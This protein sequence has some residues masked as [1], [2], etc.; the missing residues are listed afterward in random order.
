MKNLQQFFVPDKLASLR[1]DL[2]LSEQLE[3]FSRTQIQSLIKEGKVLVNQKEVRKVA[4]L[5]SP[6]DCVDIELPATENKTKL[7]H[8]NIPLDIL[9]ED[10]DVVV[11]NKPAG[12]VV[13]PAPGHTS[14]TLVNALLYHCK[15]FVISGNPIRPGIVHRLDKNTS[16]VLVVAK[17]PGSYQHLSEQVKE[18]AFSRRY[19]ALVKGIPQSPQGTIEAGIGRS[20]LDP[21]RMS[22]TGVNAREAIT[23]FYLREN[24]SCFSL[25]ELKLNTGRTHQIRV[26]LRFIG[27]PIVGDPIYGFT[28]YDLLNLPAP[29]VNALNKLPGQALHA[30]SLGFTHPRTEQ[31]L[32]FT[33][34]LPNYFQNILNELHKYFSDTKSTIYPTKL[35]KS[36]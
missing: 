6:G 7:T 20:L 30:G 9:Y 16:G 27:H 25:L 4:F 1:L 3:G 14:G 21:K 35:G 17:N 18:R 29:V 8:E 22:V 28:D 32:E 5:I 26:H 23:H 36:R 31:F 34:P 11:V 24:F 12:L 19:F 13:H 10:K 15:D 2:F 33:A